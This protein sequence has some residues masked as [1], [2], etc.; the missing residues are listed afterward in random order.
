MNLLGRSNKIIP[1]KN[2]AQHLEG[3]K[4]STAALSHD[5]RPQHPFAEHTCLDLTLLSPGEQWDHREPDIRV[6]NHRNSTGDSDE[7]P[8]RGPFTLV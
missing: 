2:F 5:Q 3:R 1:W 8:G 6:R 7:Q 4:C